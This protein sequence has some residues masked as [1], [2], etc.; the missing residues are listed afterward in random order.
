MVY[1]QMSEYH[2]QMFFKLQFFFKKKYLNGIYM[3]MD[4]F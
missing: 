1:L 2:I 4:A 3:S